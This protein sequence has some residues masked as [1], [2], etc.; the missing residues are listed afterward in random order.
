MNKSDLV[1]MVAQDCDLGH[2]AV[3]A[4]L[5]ALIKTIEQEVAAGGSVVLPGFGS[6]SAVE[7]KARQGRN[8]RTGESLEIPASRSIKFKPGKQLKDKIA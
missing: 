2:E 4:A 7:R 6:F 5:S 3:G 1:K 8:P